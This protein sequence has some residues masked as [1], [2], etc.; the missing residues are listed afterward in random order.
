MIE[1]NDVDKL[2]SELEALRTALQQD[3][4]SMIPQ[5]ESRIKKT[6]Q[7][8]SDAAGGKFEPAIGSV[9]DLLESFEA[10][11]HAQVK[12]NESAPK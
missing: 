9:C 7:M 11:M 5:L 6:R 10:D 4:T 3:R 8:R 1:Q 2:L 12:L